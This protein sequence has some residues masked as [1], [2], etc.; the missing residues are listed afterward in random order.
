M[1]VSYSVY[2]VPPEVQLLETV[3]SDEK[4]NSKQLI[5]E[6]SAFLF[7][8]WHRTAHCSKGIEMYF[9]FMKELYMWMSQLRHEHDLSLHGL[10]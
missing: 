3:L 5:D 10:Q 7:N 6:K 8:C 4:R 2:S 1:L 9:Q